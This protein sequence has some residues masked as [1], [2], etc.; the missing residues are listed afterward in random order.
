VRLLSDLKNVEVRIRKLPSPRSLEVD[1]RGLP[2]EHLR[3]T[4]GL[5]RQLMAPSHSRGPILVGTARRRDVGT[6][7]L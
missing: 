2:P 7:P 4:T 1:S 3:G 6:G 5:I